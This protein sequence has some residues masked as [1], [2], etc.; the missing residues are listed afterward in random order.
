MKH[1]GLLIFFVAGTC[2]GAVIGQLIKA[3][4]Q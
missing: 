1:L 2:V 3:A 4:C